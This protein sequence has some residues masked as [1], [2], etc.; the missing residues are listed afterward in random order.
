[1]SNLE[2]TTVAAVRQ[3]MLQKGLPEVFRVY[4]EVRD[5]HKKSSMMLNHLL[6]HENYLQSITHDLFAF[7]IVHSLLLSD[8]SSLFGGFLSSIYTGTHYDDV[9]IFATIKDPLRYIKNILTSILG[10]DYHE[11]TLEKTR[12]AYAT[13]IKIFAKY[14]GV[15]VELS[16]DIVNHAQIKHSRMSGQFHPITWGRSLAYD[17]QVGVHMLDTDVLSF[18]VKPSVEYVL[19]CLKNKKD[20]WIFVPTLF[21]TLG[22]RLEMYKRYFVE[23]SLKILD[24]GVNVEYSVRV[25][26]QYADIIKRIEQ[27]EAC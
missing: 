17:S 23:R 8:N 14:N 15:D 3:S 6:K 16:V 12:K 27:T 19:S 7:S 20:N 18:V 25:P 21:N 11:F 13:N 5:D 10:L 22:Q 9:D 1:M 4:N 24:Q 26:E 2:S